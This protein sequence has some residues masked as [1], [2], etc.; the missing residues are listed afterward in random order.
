VACRGQLHPQDDFEGIEG[1]FKAVCGHGGRGTLF[2]SLTAGQNFADGRGNIAISGEYSF[3][4]ALYFTDRETT[5]RCIL[6]DDASFRSREYDWR[7]G[8]RQRRPDRVFI[9]GIRNINISEGG[10]FTSVCPCRHCTNAARRAINC[11]GQNG[12][13]GAALGRTFVFLQTVL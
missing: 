5:E 6:P 2:A 9:E 4:E 1:V 3:A 13:T 8:D 10:L 12:P 11:T 7:S